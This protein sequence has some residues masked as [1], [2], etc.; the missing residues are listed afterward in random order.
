MDGARAAGGDTDAVLT[1][2]PHARRDGS[3]A[4]AITP[5][6][7]IRL[8]GHLD[9][10]WSDWLG[11]LEVRCTTDGETVVTGPVPDQAALHGILERVRDM[12]IELLQVRRLGLPGQEAS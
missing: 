12:G 9:P 2:P 10:A 3:G 8:R 4:T 11:D 5:R 7:E 6:Y 1:D